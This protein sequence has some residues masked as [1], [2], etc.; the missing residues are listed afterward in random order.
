MEGQRMVRRGFLGIFLVALAILVLEVALTRILSVVMWYHFAFVVISLAMLGLAISGVV[1]YLAPPLVRA[2]PALI[3]WFCRFAGVTT[4]FAL[5]YLARTPFKTEA[6]SE[7]FSH[8]V[9][10]FYVVAL[11]PFLFGGFA[12]S[13]ALA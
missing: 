4:V 13:A 5:L 9:A 2:A 6:A 12:I 8:E 3:P 7:I 11:L 1:L 10:I